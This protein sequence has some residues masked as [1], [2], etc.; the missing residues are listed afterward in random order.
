MGALGGTSLSTLDAGHA[1]LAQQYCDQEIAR[2]NEMIKFLL[3]LA[4]CCDK[5]RPS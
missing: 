2:A 1:A 4:N 5:Y 3:W